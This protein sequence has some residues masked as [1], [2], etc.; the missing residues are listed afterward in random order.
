MQVF[1]NISRFSLSL[2]TIA[3]VH[4]LRRY[5]ASQPDDF[6]AQVGRALY[7]DLLPGDHTYY[8]M[9]DGDQELPRI[10]RYRCRCCWR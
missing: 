10:R 4:D 7:G 3:S 1:G 8:A 2:P 6:F 5:R 9:R